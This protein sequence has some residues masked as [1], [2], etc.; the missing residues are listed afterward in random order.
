ML[1]YCIDWGIRFLK[2]QVLEPKSL[3]KLLEVIDTRYIYL[4]FF[5]NFI[6]NTNCLLTFTCSQLPEF[7]G[8]SCT[9]PYE[10]GCLR[11]NKGPWN[12]PEVMKVRTFFGFVI[13]LMLFVDLYIYNEIVTIEYLG[14]DLPINQVLSFVACT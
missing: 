14:T 7:L 12:D 9:C 6:H 11:S 2:L 3:H 4:M 8:G 13:L 5:E 10:G 1:S